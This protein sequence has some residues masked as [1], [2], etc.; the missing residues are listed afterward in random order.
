ME[1]VG[2]YS[3]AFVYSDQNFLITQVHLSLKRIK[4][5][6]KTKHIDV[7]RLCKPQIEQELRRNIF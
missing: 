2:A 7:N 1:S 4:Q 6:T 3:G 5:K